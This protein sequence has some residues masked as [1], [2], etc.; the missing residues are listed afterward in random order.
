M[1]QCAIGEVTVRMYRGILG[2][3]FLLRQQDGQKWRNILID[4]GVLQG[5]QGARELMKRIVEDLHQTTG[6][7]L[8]LVVLTH[9]HHDHL[10]GFSYEKE[11]FFGTDF[12][13]HE[14]W[15][16]WT[17]NPNDPQAIALHERFDKSKSALAKVVQLTGMDDPR[18]DTV[19]GLAAF[20]EPLPLDKTKKKTIDL[21]KDKAGPRATRYLEPGD[22]VQP[23]RL[24]LLS[25][26]VMG[27]PRS[28]KSLRKD[29]PSKGAAK[30]VYLTDGEEALALEDRARRVLKEP[31]LI[32]DLPFAKPHRRDL[33]EVE[34][35]A[36]VSGK[37]A[38]IEQR[39]FHEG[40][41]WRRIEREWLDSAETLA[42][43][44]DS[45]TNNTSLVLAFE[46]P[47]G[48]VLLFPGDAQVGNWLS[49]GDQTYPREP[50]ADYAAPVTRDDILSRVTLYKVGH[51]C[52]HNATLRELGLEKMTDS[53]LVAMIPVVAEVAKGNDWNMPFPELLHALLERTSGR[54]LSG[55]SDPQAELDAFAA[56]P[57]DLKKPARLR[58]ADDGLWVELDIT[59]QC[60]LGAD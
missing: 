51:H 10:S 43:K 27:P 13:I 36:Q 44:M 23:V 21:L 41:Q 55:D 38:S 56:A 54:V 42:L 4:C 8:D 9:E 5:V 17:E 32:A 28:E 6:G 11:R 57:T 45:D 16:A 33:D 24:P 39:Y 26:M 20:I 22:V 14:L 49:W 12:T 37:A 15:M 60:S 30:E 47:D 53:R 19:K 58:Y 40:N 59:Y 31:P 18:I 52:S 35:G 50:A 1:R 3:C 7:D 46:L 2:D 29:A 48:Q 25:A 34:R